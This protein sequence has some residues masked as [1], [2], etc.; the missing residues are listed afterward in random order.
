VGFETACVQ[1]LI[2]FYA[3]LDDLPAITNRAYYIDPKPQHVNRILRLSPEYL[4][5]GSGQALT[6]QGLISAKPVVTSATLPTPALL[7][8]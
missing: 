8:T 3:L 4:R 2:V 5:W 7:V 6:T 1:V